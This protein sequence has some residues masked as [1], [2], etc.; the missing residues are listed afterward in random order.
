MD[1]VKI[2]QMMGMPN[3]QCWQGHILGL[4]SDGIVYIDDGCEWVVYMHLKF[5]KE[6]EK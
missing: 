3:D 2:I 6:T 4:G 5:S 1:D